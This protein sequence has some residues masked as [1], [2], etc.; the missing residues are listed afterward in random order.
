[1]YVVRVDSE[2]P[3]DEQRREAF[4]TAG[5]T[6]EVDYLVQMEQVDI[7]RDWYTGL[8]KDYQISWKRDPEPQLA[9]RIR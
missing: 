1:M 6:P 2:E 5:L 8:E 9:V 7:I 3:T 4:F